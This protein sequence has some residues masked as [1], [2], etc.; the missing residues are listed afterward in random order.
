MNQL[1]IMAEA[2][3]RLGWWEHCVPNGDK[4]PYGYNYHTHN[5]QEKFGVPDIQIVFPID[6]A[7]AHE[8]IN[9]IIYKIEKQG[10]KLKPNK[11]YSN[12]AGGGYKVK[13]IEA[14]ECG[15]PVLRMLLPDVDGKYEG[16][17]A[18]QL[19]MLDNS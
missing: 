8:L 4:T 3:E 16:K 14:I 10:L 12:I 18:K 13:F 7:T 5:F 19:T 9:V 17:Y 2:A 11:Y 6:P 1:K 15:R